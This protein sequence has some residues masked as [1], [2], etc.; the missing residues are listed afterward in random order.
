MFKRAQR[1]DF[2]FLTLHLKEHEKRSMLQMP[3]CCFQFWE[4]S[5]TCNQPIW[6]SWRKSVHYKF[7]CRQRERLQFY[8][9]HFSAFMLPDVGSL[10]VEINFQKWTSVRKQGCSQPAFEWW[11]WPWTTCN[12][13]W[14]ISYSKMIKEQFPLSLWLGW[15]SM[16]LTTPQES[17]DP[18]N[19]YSV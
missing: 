12:Q 10:W 14:W 2:V 5:K 3:L 19:A 18:G 6:Q 8:N 7:C 11:V 13:V 16:C 15:P 9:N 4:A 17:V 1:N